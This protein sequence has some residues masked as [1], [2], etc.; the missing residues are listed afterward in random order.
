M[1]MKVCLFAGAI[2]AFGAATSQG[3]GAATLDSVKERG[4]LT[5]EW[6]MPVGGGAITQW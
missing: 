2:V 4:R 1:R 5:P 6:K 3:A